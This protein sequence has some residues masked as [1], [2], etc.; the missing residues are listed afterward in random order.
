MRIC[1]L[2]LTYPPRDTEGIVRHRQVLATELARQGHDVHVVTCGATDCVRHEAGMVVHEVT[3]REINHFSSS[4]P[5]MDVMLSQSQVL[6]EGLSRVVS[7]GPCDIMD[8]PFWSLQGLV[9]ILK[10]DC[11]TVI[12]LQTTRAQLLEINAQQPQPGN[13]ALLDLERLCLGR[14]SSIMADSHSI[15]ETVRCHH[16]LPSGARSAV[17]HLGVPALTSPIPEHRSHETVEGLIVGQ[18]ERREDTPILLEILLE[19]LRRYPNLRVRFVGRDSSAN[20]GG[21]LHYRKT[22]PEFFHQ[23]DPGFTDRVIFEGY[24]DEVRLSHCYQE[25]DFLLA[26]SLYESIGLVY[27]EAMRAALPVVAFASEGANEIFEK[28]D[29]HGAY[30]AEPGKKED[31]MKVIGQMVESPELR[32]RLGMAGLS[33]FKEAFTAEAMAR[34]HVE[35]YKHVLARSSIQR[36]PARVIYQVMEVLEVGDAVSNIARRNACLLAELHQPK[37]IL[38]RYAHEEV[39]HVTQ[40]LRQVLVNPDCG[41]IFHYWAYNT[42]IWALSVSRGPKALYYHNITPPHYFHYDSATYHATSQGYAQL[43]Q[44]LKRVDF[45]IGD[46]RYNL[47]SLS[48]YLDRPKPAI[49]IY[50]GVEVSQMQEASYDQAL[51]AH[52]RQPGHVNIVFVGRIARNKRQDQVM[53]VFDYYWREVNR[54]ASLWLVGGDAN[55]ASYCDELEEF[56]QSLASG[57]E[58]MFT[59]KVSDSQVNTYLR[60]ADVFLCASE[61]EGFCVPIVEAMALDVPVLAYA[62]AAVPETMGGS[63]L[64]IHQWDV[65]RVAELM[66]VVLRDDHVR[67][68]ILAGQ[69]VNLQRFESS[70]ACLRLEAVVNYLQTGV[71]SPLFERNFN[72]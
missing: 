64:L 18:L 38:V 72:A 21:A 23:R 40:P 39:K 14:A 58:I 67:H 46:S 9:A 22:Y 34:S 16:G 15:L 26:P 51:F 41:L 33:R 29:A 2:T 43:P 66:H 5:N 47:E 36:H 37:E 3:G 55:D 59:G 62:A 25:A 1:L 45:L 60:A 35:F 8:I 57:K 56:R 27:L 68:K 10:C 24:V 71:G 69:R 50:P 7:E 12:F 42:S 31:L 28:G 48:P 20:H 13:Q 61:H 44:I 4:Y 30:L 11:P 6:H 65:P 17:I 19:L 53:R 63:G 52:L 32:Q 54:H 49:V 70:V